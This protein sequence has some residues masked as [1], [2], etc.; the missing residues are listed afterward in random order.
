MGPIHFKG[1][2]SYIDGN[3]FDAKK[4]TLVDSVL[5]CGVVDQEDRSHMKRKLVGP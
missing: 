5:D 2:N 4:S 1:I 3:I